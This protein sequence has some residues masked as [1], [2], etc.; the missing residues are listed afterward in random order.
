MDEKRLEHLKNNLEIARPNF[1]QIAK[2]VGAE[3]LA[4]LVETEEVNDN[5]SNS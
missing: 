4:P 3:S 5:E 1:G 2:P